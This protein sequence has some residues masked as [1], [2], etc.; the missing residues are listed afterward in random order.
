MDKSRTRFYELLQCQPNATDEELK[1]AY[2]V[3]SLKLHPDKGGDPEAFK[4]M[5]Y[6]YDVL[7]EPHS[8]WIY[9]NF[10]EAGVKAKEGTQPSPEMIAHIFASLGCCHR[11]LIVLVLTLILGYLLLFPILLSIRWDHPHSM[12]FAHVFIPVWLALSVILVVCVCCIPIQR[13]DDEAEQRSMYAGKICSIIAVAILFGFLWLLV[14]RLDGET[15]H[16]YLWVLWPWMVVELGLL[17]AKMWVVN[18]ITI[19]MSSAEKGLYAAAETSPHVFNLI[20][21]CLLAWKMD[22]SG[23]S[24]WEVFWPFWVQFGIGVCLQLSRCAF[25]RSDVEE[26]EGEAGLPDGWEALWSSQEKRFYYVNIS[27]GDHTYEKPQASPS[28]AKDENHAKKAQ[29]AITMIGLVLKLM[30]VVL[31]CYKLAHPRAYPAWVVFL[32]LFVVTGCCCCTASCI[33]CCFVP[34]SSDEDDEERGRFASAD[35]KADGVPGATYGT[36]PR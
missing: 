30:L 12:D 19:V 6:A 8:R 10:G 9:D 33:V 2:R 34:P 24:W 31:I 25:V 32:P 36:I 7:K 28:Q 26:S 4:D 5:K 29:I 15:K 17:V 23:M 21:I 35:D 16:S 20:F 13:P 11:L 22:G 1:K 27:T 18:Q 3:R 14:L